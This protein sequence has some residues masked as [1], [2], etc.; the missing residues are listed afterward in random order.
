VLTVWLPKSKLLASSDIV[1][2]AAATP[3]PDS[4]IGTAVV[5]PLWVMLSVPLRLPAA[6]GEKTTVIVQL[7]LAAS[8]SL[9]VPPLRA[10]S[11]LTLAARCV[12]AAMR[13]ART[14]TVCGE[15]AWPTVVCG[16]AS[17]LGALPR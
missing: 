12:S 15:L 10:K 2:C 8:E 9:Q 1:G 11:P 3:V 7:P 17:E 16:K 14:V 4:P 6:V 5:K 13:L